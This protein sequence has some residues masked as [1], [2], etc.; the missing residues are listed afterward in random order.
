MLVPLDPNIKTLPDIPHT[1]SYVIRKRQLIDSFRELP[2]EKRPP[3]D[4]I[5]DGTSE[6]LDEWF[7]KV[8]K[9][10]EREEDNTIIITDIEE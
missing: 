6:D 7:D 2:R 5:W 10:N 3:D 4:I 1:I 8:F 9:R